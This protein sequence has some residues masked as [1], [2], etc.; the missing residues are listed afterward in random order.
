[1]LLLYSCDQQPCS[2]SSKGMKVPTKR[3][4][5]MTITYSYSVEFVVSDKWPV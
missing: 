4:D 5:A 3:G 2:S 1:M